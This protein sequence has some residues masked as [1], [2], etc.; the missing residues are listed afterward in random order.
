MSDQ[1]VELTV[2]QRLGLAEFAVLD[3]AEK[4]DRA[5]QKLASQARQI[6]DGMAEAIRAA[7][8]EGWQAC[9]LAHLEYAVA[10]DISLLDD[11]YAK[12]ERELGMQ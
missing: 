3:L 10:G 2:E 11:P 4:L 8:S 7:K 12:P 9:L 1:S 6:S 5:N